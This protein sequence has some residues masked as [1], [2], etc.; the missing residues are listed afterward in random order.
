MCISCER[1]P[2]EII[3]DQVDVTNAWEYHKKR[4]DYYVAY[5]MCPE[6]FVSSG[7]ITY[8]E[9]LDAALL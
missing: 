3:A 4:A 8:E 7:W 5:G 1:T 9:W 6:E 2:E